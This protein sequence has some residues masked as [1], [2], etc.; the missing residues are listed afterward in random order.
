MMQSRTYVS[1]LDHLF[2][3]KNTENIAKGSVYKIQYCLR[4]ETCFWLLALSSFE[5]MLISNFPQ[6][7]CSQGEKQAAKF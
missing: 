3:C 6:Y 7:K 5:I 2:K 1:Y 4:A